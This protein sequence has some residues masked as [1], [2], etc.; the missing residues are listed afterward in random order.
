[1]YYCLEDSATE[2]GDVRGSDA[3]KKAYEMGRNV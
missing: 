1:M 2:A 3:M